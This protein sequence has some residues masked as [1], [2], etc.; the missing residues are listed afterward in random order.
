M[1][2]LTD[3]E[4]Q[5]VDEYLID[6]NKVQAYRRAF[7]AGKS[8]QSDCVKASQLFRK[9]KVRAELKAAQSDA[10]RRTQIR[11]DKVLKTL[12][13]VAWADPLE[14]FDN[15]GNPR[16]MRKVPYQLRQAIQTVKVSKEQTRREGTKTTKSSVIEFKLNDRMA[17]LDKLMKHLGLTQEITPLDAFIAALPAGLGKQ[18]RAALAGDVPKGNDSGGTQGGG[19]DKQ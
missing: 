15:R 9:P 6:R 1:A 7:G 3:K 11:A 12:A 13:G 16:P 8:Y 5:F 18:V 17:A 10:Q 14:L 4:R 19:L 2:G